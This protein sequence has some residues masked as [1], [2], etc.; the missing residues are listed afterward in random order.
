MQIKLTLTTTAALRALADLIDHNP[1]GFELVSAAPGNADKAAAAPTPR[2]AGTARAT[3][4]APAAAPTTN[5]TKPKAEAP[6]A[7][8]PPAEPFP[9]AEL[10]AK[11][12]ELLKLDPAKPAEIVAGF[13]VGKFQ[14][15][16][17]DKWAE[18]KEAVEAAIAEAGQDV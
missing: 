3:A 16:P 8:E 12:I 11:V 17:V 13:G 7:D 1:A 5:K 18:A 10:K 2:S 4:P 14:E 6:P 15:L 9:Y